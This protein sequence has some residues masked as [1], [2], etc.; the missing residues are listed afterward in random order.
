M[1]GIEAVRI[2]REA[3]YTQPIVA[4]TANAVIGNADMFLEN[5]FDDF[6]S[7]PIDIR[8]LNT[9]LKKYIRDKQPPEV[10]EAAERRKSDVFEDGIKAVRLIAPETEIP[11]VDITKGLERYNN[12]EKVYLKILHAYAANLRSMLEAYETVNNSE[13]ELS[14]YK[15]RIHGIKGASLN[16]YAEPLAEI[17]S[18]L[19]KA[20]AA[21]NFEYVS[22]HHSAFLELGRKLVDNLDEMLSLIDTENPKPVKEKPDSEVLMKLS[23][24]CEVYDIDEVDAAMEELEKYRYESDG[25]LVEWLKECLALMKYPEIVE[26]LS[27]IY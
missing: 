24:A 21:K 1:D 22:K 23:N 16:I 3:G 20:A 2:I 10:I 17:T 5:G 7:K 15:I 25:G 8:Q 27:S 14:D 4:L 11:G 6:I 26:K 18:E 12:N 13:D 9:I 19:E